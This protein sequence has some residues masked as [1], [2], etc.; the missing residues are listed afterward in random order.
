MLAPAR[1]ATLD[2]VRGFAVMGIVLLN[3]VDFAMPGYA[4]VDPYFY[5][6]ADG[7][8]WAVWAV[9]YV[10]ADGKMRGLFTMLFGASTV[11]VAEQAVRS[12]ESPVR[13]HYARI[14]ALV[15]FG[16]IHA[17]LIW[18][19]DILV[20][21]SIVGAVVFL[22]WRWPTRTLLA[23]GI[24]L[25][26]FKLL[27]GLTD[28]A[29]AKR[30]EAA[31]TAPDARPAVQRQWREYLAAQTPPVAE[32]DTELAAYR[33]SYRDALRARTE[34]AVFMQTVVHQ[35][36][37]SDTTALMLIG[38]ALFRLGF[39]SGAWSRRSYWRLALLSYAICLPLYIPLVWWIDATR[40]SPVTLVA[41]EAIHLSLLRPWLALAHAAMVILFVQSGAWRWLAERLAATGRMAFSNYIGT[42]IVCTLIFNGYGLGWFGYLERWQCYPIVLGVWAIMLLW[43]KPW[44]DRFAYG[45]L[46]WLWRSAARWQWQPLR[47]AT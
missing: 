43:S 38:M 35:Q 7:A 18:S 16:M 12:G 4:Y 17:Y 9:N 27:G 46:E 6:G 13:V 30:F 20:L 31:A 26:A 28:Y 2:A 22:A 25:L 10:I 15:M 8:N 14:A 3:I 41:T 5:G 33:G 36:S 44:L 32:R 47:R 39:F 45:P 23:F 19:G 37:L 29:A 11:L 1:L 42:S 24:I 34:M 40:F 21:Y